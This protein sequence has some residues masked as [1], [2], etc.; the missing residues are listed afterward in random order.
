M[1]R[2]K[3]EVFPPA[4]PSR[5]DIPGSLEQGRSPCDCFYPLIP[6]LLLLSRQ[7]GD[8]RLGPHLGYT[9]ISR[10]KPHGFSYPSPTLWHFQQL[11]WCTKD[12]QSVKRESERSSLF[13]VANDSIFSTLST[14]SVPGRMEGTPGTLSGWDAVNQHWGEL[15]GIWQASSLLFT[16]HSSA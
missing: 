10:P 7:G 15:R 5:T 4:S 16:K 9:F 13:A 2:W 1:P 11:W 14:F 8:L 3:V 12:Q 6:E